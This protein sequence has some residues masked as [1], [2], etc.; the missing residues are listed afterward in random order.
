MD[1]LADVKIAGPGRHFEGELP[2][3]RRLFLLHRTLDLFNPLPALEHSA[4]L[5]NK[6]AAF[7]YT[8]GPIG[9]QLKGLLVL[10]H[11]RWTINR[12]LSISTKRRIA[13]LRVIAF[14]SF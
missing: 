5:E 9:E 14:P 1:E 11:R 6:F 2:L 13:L 4:C 8:F 3:H 10:Q 7:L 12:I